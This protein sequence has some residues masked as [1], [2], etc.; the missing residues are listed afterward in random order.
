MTPGGARAPKRL[1]FPIDAPCVICYNK[2]TYKKEE[3]LWD[4]NS[5]AGCLV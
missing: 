3:L 4:L 2:N 1:D 5:Q